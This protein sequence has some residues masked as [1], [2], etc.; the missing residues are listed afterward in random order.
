MNMGETLIVIGYVAG[1]ILVCVLIVVLTSLSRKHFNK[2]AVLPD[3]YRSYTGRAE[4]SVKRKL[5]EAKKAMRAS[6]LKYGG[7]RNAEKAHS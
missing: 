1:V 3:K 7:E 6:L 4:G 2:V 5:H